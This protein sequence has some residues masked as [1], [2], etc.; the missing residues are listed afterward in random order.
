[1]VLC[2]LKEVRGGLGDLCSSQCLRLAWYFW[3]GVRTEDWPLFVLR[4]SFYSQCAVVDNLLTCAF[5]YDRR[6]V[7]LAFVC[8]AAC[9]LCITELQD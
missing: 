8:C 1:M 4:K 5:V 7:Y 6:I 3:Q 9:D 2:R